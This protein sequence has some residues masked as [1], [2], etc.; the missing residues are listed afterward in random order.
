MSDSI[1]LVQPPVQDFYLTRKRTVPYGLASIASALEASGFEPQI[2]DGLATDKSKSMPYPPEFSN[3]NPFYGRSDI[4]LFS[5]FHDFCHFGYSF[6]HIGKIVRDQ[7]PFLVGISSLFTPYAD[8]ALATAR[9]VKKFFPRTLVVLGGHHPTLF[10]EQVLVDEAVDFILR[11]EGE[12]SLPLLCRAL[13]DGSDLKQVPGI[14]FREKSGPFIH[15]PV[16]MKDLS[17]YPLPQSRL[18]RQD[19]YQRKKKAAI[20]VVTSR[21]CPMPCSYCSVSSRSSH[22]RFRQRDVKE[23]LKEIEAQALVRDIGFI[24]F[25]DENLTL[26]KKYFMT[27]LDGLD[28]IFPE[29]RPELRAMNGL[30]PPSL[31]REMI[32]AMK[33]SGFQTLNLSLGSTSGEQLKRF[34]RPDVRNA[35][36][37]T[38]DLAQKSGL[39]AV[40][41]V[42]AG[43]PNQTAASSLEDLLYLAQK[44]TLAGLSVFYPAPG[45]LDWD[46]CREND[47]LPQTFSLMRSSALPLDHT[48]TRLQSITLLRLTRILNYMKS[49]ID[50][51]K[52]L[53]RPRPF[54]GQ[55]KIKPSLNREKI[56][57]KLLAF[58][59]SDGSVFG[60]NRE[61][62]L[63]EHLVDKALTQKF[64][65]GLKQTSVRGI[66]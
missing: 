7:R 15:P 47:L 26:N 16:W 42:I 66:L 57:E 58:F 18:I 60:A 55:T 38:L 5:L 36:D 19:Y 17:D 46:L 53:P 34:N 56:S 32:R 43:A 1:L 61:G 10:P 40:S 24:D 39:S 21:G 4:S 8:Q 25:E 3:L 54:N 41:Y 64:L 22:G 44:R 62:N 35:H 48:T 45:S 51:G 13:T 23:V 2:L 59:L 14:G 20:S 50:A 29:N 31:D 63:Y 28:K 37:L 27:L 33:E 6:E 52:T 65:E 30:F 9:T 12:I 49:R 11:G